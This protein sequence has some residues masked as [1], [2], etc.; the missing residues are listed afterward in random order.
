MC[1]VNGGLIADL[2]PQVTFENPR[3]FASSSA[4]KSHLNKNTKSLISER[5]VVEALHQDIGASLKKF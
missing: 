5:K 1:F 4:F 3:G 2:A